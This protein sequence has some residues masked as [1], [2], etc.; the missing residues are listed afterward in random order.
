MGA[1]DRYDVKAVKDPVFQVNAFLLRDLDVGSSALVIPSLGNNL[2][3]FVAS[4]PDGRDLEIILGAPPGTAAENAWRWGNPILF[5]F[6]NR[7]RGGQYSFGG[8]RYQMDANMP[9][10][11][12]LHGL[13]CYLP[14]RIDKAGPEDGGAVICCSFDAA[15]YPDVLRQYP[16]PFRLT[17]TYTLVGNSL[18]CEAEIANVGTGPLPLGFGLHPYLRAPLTANGRRE[19]CLIAVPA[20]R[21]WRLD[22]DKLPTGVQELVPAGLNFRQPRPLNSTYLDHSY[23]D[24]ERVYGQAICRL[25][26]PGAGVEVIEQFGPEFT[27]IVV[28]APGD[29]PTVSFEPYSCVTDAINL[30]TERAD[31]GLIL[32]GTDENWKGTVRISALP[33]T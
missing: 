3:S 23:T 5:P 24:L 29:R 10:G 18:L 31:T 13:V 27:E 11:H 8:R 15:E 17:V 19:E 1:N 14:W 7:V 26:D 25:I 32:L 22:G 21:A 2:M 12:H 6:P 30:S 9:E 20:R 4:M 33:A 28:L 16:F